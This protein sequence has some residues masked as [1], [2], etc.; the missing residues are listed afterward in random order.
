MST[1]NR[2]A[3]TVF[4]GMKTD[5]QFQESLALLKMLAQSGKSAQAGRIKP[6]EKAFADVRKRI[7]RR[8]LERE[9]RI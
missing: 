1:H 3:R 7:A 5:E 2:E 6:V 9:T 4:Q 8:R